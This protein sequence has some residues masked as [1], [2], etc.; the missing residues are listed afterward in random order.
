MFFG[1]SWHCLCEVWHSSN[2]NVHSPVTSKHWAL[3]FASNNSS[4]WEPNDPNVDTSRA[5]TGRKQRGLSKPLPLRHSRLHHP[6]PANHN[7]KE[8]SNQWKIDL[9]SHGLERKRMEKASAL[10]VAL[11]HEAEHN[12]MHQNTTKR[13]PGER[14]VSPSSICSPHMA[15]ASMQ[16]L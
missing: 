13:D 9:V 14:Q 6:P 2:K 8:C 10:Q 12:K 11:E 4:T 15:K 3:H 1:I 5:S 7:L 16:A